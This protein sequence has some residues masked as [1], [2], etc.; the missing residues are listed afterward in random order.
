MK[1]HSK[2]GK[3]NIVK[4]DQ[5]VVMD[6][7]DNIENLRLHGHGKRNSPEIG[8][9]SL[10]YLISQSSLTPIWSRKP[11]QITFFIGVPT[12]AQ[13]H[14]AGQKAARFFPVFA[15]QALLVL[16]VKE[17]YLTYDNF[18]NEMDN[19]SNDKIKYEPNLLFKSKRNMKPQT[20]HYM[21]SNYETSNETSNER[22]K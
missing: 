20:Y 15:L 18:G 16:S 5:N 21:E 10:I 9:A 14:P 13:R 2:N 8:S 22:D 11:S 4:M 12:L 19:I 17:M 7:Y 1:L 6:S 3:L